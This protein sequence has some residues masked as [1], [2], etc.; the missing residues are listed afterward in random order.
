MADAE[1]LSLA[2]AIDALA[3]ARG[4]DESVAADAKAYAR[5]EGN[6]A[7]LLGAV[8]GTP[9]PAIGTMPPMGHRWITRRPATRPMG[10]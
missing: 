3:E 1:T 6:F 4:I 8:S 7:I 10:L 5:G 2:A 9:R